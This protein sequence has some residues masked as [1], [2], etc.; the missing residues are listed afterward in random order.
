MAV[1]RVAFVIQRCGDEVV[2]GA[3]SLCLQVAQRLRAVADVE[4]LTT[5]AIDYQT[6]RNEY[7]AGH[8]YVQ[9]VRVRRFPVDRPRNPAAFDRISRDVAFQLTQTPLER[10]EE[11]MRAQGPMS[12]Q[13][14]EYLGDYEA[15]YDSIVFFG[16][17][18]ATTY[19]GLPRVA[20]KAI[21]VPFAHDEWPI[22]LP[23]WERIFDL[24]RG[25]VFSSEEERE[26]VRRRLPEKNIRGEVIGVGIEAPQERNPERFRKRFKIEEPFLLYLGRIEKA[27]GVDVLFDDFVRYRERKRMPKK[28]VLVGREHTRIPKHR[29]LVVAGQVGEQAKWDAISACDLLV[30]PSQFESLSL[31]VLEAWACGKPVL[32]N[33]RSSVLVGQCRRAQGGIW[34]D[35]HDEF[36]AALDLLDR[37]IRLTLGRQGQEH[38]RKNYNWERV[39]HA[40]R[41]LF[42]ALTPLPFSDGTLDFNDAKWYAQDHRPDEETRLRYG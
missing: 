29:D 11:W 3:E 42:D 37:D 34:Y 23:M 36:E 26:F 35:S 5:C 1:R 16:Y 6:W 25:L 41:S 31:V 40:Y 4:I 27:K 22:R 13:L 38:V 14:F 2:G 9:G 19:F 24:P 18:Y 20:H 7:P 15:L 39:I 28:L 33:A 32:V 8:C 17:L 10:Q 12:T 21:L 30:M